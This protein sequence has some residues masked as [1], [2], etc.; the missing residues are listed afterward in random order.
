MTDFSPKIP[1]VKISFKMGKISYIYLNVQ[2]F[3]II[4]LNWSCHIRSPKNRTSSY[5]YYN[6]L[7]YQILIRIQNH[8]WLL[9]F[10]KLLNFNFRS[11]FPQKITFDRKMSFEVKESILSSHCVHCNRKNCHQQHSIFFDIQCNERFVLFQIPRMN[12]NQRILKRKF[13]I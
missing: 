13:P 3:F 1:E 5:Y 7:S 9:R 2:K 11:K 10:F 8:L 6:C 4:R 12:R